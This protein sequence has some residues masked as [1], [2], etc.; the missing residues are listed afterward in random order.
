MSV[1]WAGREGPEIKRVSKVH[2]CEFL[3]SSVAPSNIPGGGMASD[4]H[5]FVG[6]RL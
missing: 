2:G 3:P 1:A 4:T 6:P 5:A